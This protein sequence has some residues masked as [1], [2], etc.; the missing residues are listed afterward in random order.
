[1]DTQPS[2]P[3]P[4][5]PAELREIPNVLKHLHR[6]TRSFVRDGRRITYVNIYARPIGPGR[7]PPL[8]FITAK[9][10][11][12]EGVAC[13][14]D[15]ARA[16]IL[17]LQVY[18]E[19][20]S[21]VALG[22]AHDWLGFVAYMQEPDGRFTNFIADRDGAK[23]ERG[24]TSYSGGKWW[25]ARA[26]WALALAWRV[27]GED[28]YLRLFLRGRL[29]P[30]SD[31]K[32][33]AVHALTLM[34]LYQVRSHDA[35]CRR[36]CA[37]CDAI[38]SSGPG[39]FRDRTAQA[40]VALWGYHQLQAV[41]RAARLFSRLDYVAACDATV[42]NLVEPALAQ[43]RYHVYPIL[44]DQQCA[45]DVSTVVLGL[46]ELYRLTARP[47]YRR[48]ALAWAAWLDGDNAAGTPVY[49]RETGLCSD[50]IMN[51]TVSL[52]C[53]AESAIEAGFVELAR[54]RLAN[55]YPVGVDA[56]AMRGVSAAALT[57]LMALV[58]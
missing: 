57:P 19:T 51:D 54:V 41:A 33:K 56:R 2:P 15:T 27:T 30:T 48:Q 24:L 49:D 55:D 22:L 31:M 20:G 47:L 9:E 39:Y 14:D 26:M 1:M 5:P 53:G 35:L 11:G 18:K 40:S 43:G 58:T 37:L 45:Y 6:M 12:F 13:V 46:E 44:Q 28:R 17:A 25:T 38:V 29:A 10:T 16:A 21:A 50:G 7:E 36:I 8:E 32:V 3:S 23:N 4:P 34:E 52:N 42:R